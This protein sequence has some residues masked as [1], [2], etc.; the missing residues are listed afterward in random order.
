M[1]TKN[2]RS[3]LGPFILIPFFFDQLTNM[4]I[5][6]DPVTEV[7]KALDGQVTAWNNGDL[8]KPM[9]YYW[10]LPEMLWVSKTGI[11]KGY[12][13]VLDEFKKRICR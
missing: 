1:L 9:S 7:K 8:E 4:N 13:P 5:F 11:T 12:Q 3:I 6:A 2:V 10:N